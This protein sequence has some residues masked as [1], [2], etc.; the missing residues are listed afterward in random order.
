[1]LTP[2]AQVCVFRSPLFGV[3]ATAIYGQTKVAL[4]KLRF[5]GVSFCLERIE[6]ARGVIHAFSRI[7][8]ID[9]P[10]LWVG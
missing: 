10:F 1:V 6:M 8:T 7:W 2:I 5:W 9:S 3:S 4:G